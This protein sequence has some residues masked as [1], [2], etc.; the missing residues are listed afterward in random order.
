M[1]NGV[2]VIFDYCRRFGAEIE[3]N[4]LDGESHPRVEG[5][6]PEGI[7]LIANIVSQTL[8]TRCEVHNWLQGQKATEYNDVWIIKPDGSCG[9]EICSPVSKG[10]HGIGR[11][12]AVVG[13]MK[14]SGIAKADARCSLHVH[15]EIVDLST[16]Q[17]ASVL[18]QWVKC[19]YTMLLA[20]PDRRKKNRYCQA[21]G[22][23][24]LLRA[25]H[26]LTPA[27]LI[28]RLGAYKYYTANTFH[29]SR[30]KRPTM[31]FRIADEEAC[32]DPFYIKNWIKLIIHF[33]EM[34]SRMPYPGEYDANDPHSGYL[35]LIPEDVLKIL[36]F[37]TPEN[38]CPE[39][40]ETRNWFMDRLVKNAYGQLGGIWDH[41]VID[42][43]WR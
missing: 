35:W 41:K 18:A 24:D 16:D 10:L 21:I 42:R 31:E 25:D 5:A 27:S 9:M 22:M 43:V 7:Q 2:D 37:D 3:V 20:M 13:G 32:L 38:L 33:V 34:T 29:F 14:E 19:E 4:A 6:Q 26:L 15:T 39:L 1:T 36:K 30:N 11:V 23:S 28:N 12:G 17:L 40:L 8:N